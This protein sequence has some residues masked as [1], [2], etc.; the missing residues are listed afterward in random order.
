MI[1]IIGESC[2]GK[3]TLAQMLKEKL[4]AQFFAGK[5]YLRLAKNETIA[6]W[7]PARQM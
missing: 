5:D 6:K 4:N 2:T 7:Y 3:T 1:A